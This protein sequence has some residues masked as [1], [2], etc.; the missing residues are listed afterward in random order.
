MCIVMGG[1]G[2][3]VVSHFLYL[4][5]E[6]IKFRLMGLQEAKSANFDMKLIKQDF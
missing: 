6:M 3:P 2:V 1:K 5:F 4:D